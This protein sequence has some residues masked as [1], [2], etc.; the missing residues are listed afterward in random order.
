M[1][2]LERKLE[3]DRASLAEQISSRSR[4]ATK[5]RELIAEFVGQMQAYGVLPLT[6]FRGDVVH[7]ERQRGGIGR[8]RTTIVHTR[9]SYSVV[10]EGWMLQ[11]LGTDRSHLG[12]YF[13]IPDMGIARVDQRSMPVSMKR[14]D[15]ASWGKQK[16]L[17]VV[18]P[19][20]TIN[21]AFTDAIGQKLIYVL[22]ADP[23]G[24]DVA[25]SMWSSKVDVL[26][27]TLRTATRR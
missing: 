14:T 16:V 1:G 10:G 23:D 8:R 5:G 22:G 26:A 20:D 11:D 2:D 24:S 6:I 25:Y 12:Y 17:E 7:E 9:W 4:R 19:S 3:A 27:N 18:A 21:H 15:P 13:V